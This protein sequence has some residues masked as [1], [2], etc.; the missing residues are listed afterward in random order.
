M[1]RHITN[2]ASKD[3][4]LG[5]KVQQ[6]PHLLIPELAGIYGGCQ[7]AMTKFKSL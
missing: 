6:I 4:L 5:N 1:S 2:M 7:Y 3:Q